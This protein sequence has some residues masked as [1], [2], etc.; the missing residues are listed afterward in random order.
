MIRNK[1]T[2][3]EVVALVQLHGSLNKAWPHSGAGRTTFQTI[4]SDAVEAGLAPA[5]RAGR[6]TYGEIKAH[7]AGRL[8]VRSTPK[9]TGQKCKF[10]L[11]T[12]QNNTHMHSVLWGNLNALAKFDNAR[13]IVARSVYNRFAEAATM[14][15][16]LLID[17]MNRNKGPNKY[18]WPEELDQYFVDERM[19]LAPGLVWCGETN[20]VPTAANPLSGFESYT[21][22]A[23]SVFPHPRIAVRSAASHAAEDTKFLYTTGTLTQ[24]NY[25]Q[26]RAGQM[27]EFHHCY[28][29]LLVE[30]DSSGTWF[31]RQLNADSDGTIYDLDRK[32]ENSKVT[33]G[34][35]LKAIN[36]G[37]LHPTYED[38]EA[39]DLAWGKGGIL[40]T[41]HPEYQFMH[42][43]LDGRTVNPHTQAKRLH[44]HQF[45]EWVKGNTSIEQEVADTAEFLGRALRS[46]CETKVVASNHDN[47]LVRWLYKN[48][49]FRKDPENAVYFLEAALYYWE[50]MQQDGKYPNM[51][52]W[53]MKRAL[54]LADSG[55]TVNLATNPIGYLDEDESFVLCRE[56]GGG[57]EFGMHG[58]QGANGSRGTPSGLSKM[59]RKA[60]IGDKHSAGIYD[61][62]YVA[63]VMGSLDQGYNSGPSSWSQTNIFTY[64]NGKRALATIFDGK[65]RA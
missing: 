12:A 16:K 32:V 52:E 46:W 21:G 51:T 2:I 49:D 29:A 6:K 44:H 62:L 41:L 23:S 24:I 39:S 33:T 7:V 31:T 30:V 11:T 47:F 63:G 50:K 64:Q 8:K 28:G 53:G 1:P 25:I 40:D 15:K 20:V 37:D 57:I 55:P 14:D 19:E 4:Y 5:V 58:H 59:G 26:R 56:H 10:I 22:R 61:G 27:A 48:G 36:W 65:W 38:R 3:A 60:N 34:H 43:L 54:R 18:E 13:I 17:G 9:A 45:M 42:D 35:R